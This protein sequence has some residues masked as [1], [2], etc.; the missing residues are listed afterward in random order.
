[1]NQDIWSMTPEELLAHFGGVSIC[2]PHCDLDVFS[3]ISS[4]WGRD[5]NAKT[6]KE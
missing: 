6:P 5:F 4:Q 1:M 2:L 3:L